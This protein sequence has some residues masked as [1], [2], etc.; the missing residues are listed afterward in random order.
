MS[1]NDRAARRFPIANNAV[2]YIPIEIMCSDL[3]E[4]L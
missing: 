1:S 3:E 4:P 2:Q